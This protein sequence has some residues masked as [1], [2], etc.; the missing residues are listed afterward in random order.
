MVSKRLAGVNFH[1]FCFPLEYFLDAQVRLGMKSVEL[2]AGTP[3]FWID[4]YGHEDCGKVREAMEKRGLECHV[5]TP[6]I[7]SF[8]YPLCVPDEEWRK[9]SL[10]YWMQAIDAA[11]QLDCR[12]VCLALAGGFKDI[13]MKKQWEWCL[14][15]LKRLTEEAEKRGIRLAL[16]AAEKKD[17]MIAGD[18]ETVSRMIG[19]A[20]GL[21]GALDTAA[22]AQ[23]GEEI[24]DWID[25]LGEKLI[26]VHFS[27]SVSGT[28]LPWGTGTLDGADMIKKL[29][30]GGYQGIYSLRLDEYDYYDEPDKADEKNLKGL[31]RILDEKDG[32]QYL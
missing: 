2:F 9:R 25:A 21:Y 30:A 1:Y 14:E 12:T 26:H 19:E 13:S 11:D 15:A 27:D 24:S 31:L 10:A 29:T 5:L 28:Y 4:P 7:A 17:G 32:W 16:E 18:L 23:A 6:E 3:H 8:H 22:M 20:D